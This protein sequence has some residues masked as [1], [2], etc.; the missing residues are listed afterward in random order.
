MIYDNRNLTDGERIRLNL[1][2]ETEDRNSI[3]RILAGEFDPE[4]RRYPPEPALD[5]P[6]LSTDLC[7]D[8]ELSLSEPPRGKFYHE[9]ALSYRFSEQL[10][11]DR[12]TQIEHARNK[13][14]LRIVRLVILALACA[15]ITYATVITSTW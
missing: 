9:Q 5:V 8:D 4:P 10:R 1:E 14:A 12:R 11:H 3:G 7:T 13:L 15:A 6:R 2:P